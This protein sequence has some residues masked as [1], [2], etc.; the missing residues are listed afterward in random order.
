MTI[1]ALPHLAASSSLRS[2]STDP[3]D[4]FLS[5][6][7]ARWHD[8]CRLSDLETNWGEAALV[9]G[10][11]VA[12]FRLPGNEVFAV[13]QRDPATGAH[14]MAR[15]IVGSRSGRPTIAS[16]LHKQ[17]YDLV[18]GERLDAAGT[19]LAAFAARVVGGVV[20]IAA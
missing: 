10:R 6:S 11:Q 4:P 7:P 12:L 19:P 5:A 18:T 17:V 3:D 14:V 15:G 13:E 1:T 8:V 20:Q 16:P 2:S 9:G